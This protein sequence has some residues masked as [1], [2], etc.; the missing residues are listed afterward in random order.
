MALIIHWTRTSALVDIQQM[1]ITILSGGLLGLFMIGFLT[2]RVDNLS[3]LVA[4][5]ITLL[6]VVS[7][8]FLK[9][10]IGIEYFP[11]AASKIPDDFMINVLSNTFIFVFAYIF[12]IIFRRNS[13]KNLE[14]LTIW[15]SK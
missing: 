7:W 1:C 2:K 15:T 14:N 8:L 13:R 10:D 3:A 12:S 11:K 4:T 6:S 9:S 5:A